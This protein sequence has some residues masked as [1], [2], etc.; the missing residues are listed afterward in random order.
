MTLTPTLERTF[1]IMR[2]QQQSE[3]VVSI[4]AVARELGVTRHAVQKHVQRLVQLGLVEL[5]QVTRSDG[6]CG[7]W[8]LQGGATPATPPATRLIASASA[9]PPATPATPA[10]YEF[11][12]LLAASAVHGVQ[13]NLG[14]GFPPDPPSKNNSLPIQSKKEN[15]PYGG[16]KERSTEPDWELLEDQPWWEGKR[17]G[18]KRITRSEG[19]MCEAL[20][21][22]FNRQAGTRFRPRAHCVPIIGRLREHPE[23]SFEDHAAIIE[24]ELAN[25]WGDLAPAICKV[26][27]N[28]RQ[29]DS[30]LNRVE[31]KAPKERTTAEIIAEIRRGQVESGVVV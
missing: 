22:E 3:G 26:Y 18:R 19:E 27:G 16:S 8:R 14:L 20:V 23:L 2:E 11:G 12:R 17:V 31:F 7:G 28:E 29:F 10:T 15:P 30:C 5:E 13:E 25:P 4:S 1:A 6:G 21:E 9:E 24:N